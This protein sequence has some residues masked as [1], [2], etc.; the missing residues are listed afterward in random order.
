MF[1]SGVQLALM[2][3]GSKSSVGAGVSTAQTDAHAPVCVSRLGAVALKGGI[4]GWLSKNEGRP[5]WLLFFA[6][7]SG[8][9]LSLTPSNGLGVL[10]SPVKGLRNTPPRESL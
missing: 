7:S 8:V 5:R 3:V 9:R 10:A 4:D 2:K 1:V 6:K